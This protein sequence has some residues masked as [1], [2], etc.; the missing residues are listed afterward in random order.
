MSDIITT[1]N[2]KGDR[3]V[4]VYPNIQQANIPANAIDSTRLASNSVTTG[5]LASNSVTTGKIDNKAVTDAKLNDNAVTTD[6]ILD[7]AV[8]GS[9]IA[10]STINPSKL[11]KTEF[12]PYLT[13]LTLEGNTLQLDVEEISL[14]IILPLNASTITLS[15]FL[16]ISYWNNYITGGFIKI[17]S[18]QKCFNITNMVETGSNTYNIFYLD[19]TD[20]S[21]KY[22]SNYVINTTDFNLIKDSSMDIFLTQI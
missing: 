11:N 14:K 1:L 7:S 15:D 3:T 8:T 22:I 17:A 18:S 2:K 5:K 13:A 12:S 10:N 6:K 4:N 21:I 16:S 20:G 9:K 19:Y